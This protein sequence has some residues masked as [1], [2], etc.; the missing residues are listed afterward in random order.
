MDTLI[1]DLRHS[2]RMLAKA[3]GFTAIAILALALG[4]GANTA[5][6]SVIQGVVLAPLRYFQPDR[7]VMVWESNPRF[8]RVWVSYPNFLDWQRAARSFRQIAAFTERGVDLTG[9]G[10]AEHLDGK[11]I[12]SGF[13]N[14]LGVELTLGRE[15]SRDEDQHGGALAVIISN[16]LWRSRFA[17]VRNLL[18]FLS[19]TGHSWNDGQTES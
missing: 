16:R 12:S 1:Q 2:A 6:F 9:P 10:T 5:M 14:A 18:L 19:S 8:P 17:A 4:V 15:F 3:P 7:L 11:E 13:F